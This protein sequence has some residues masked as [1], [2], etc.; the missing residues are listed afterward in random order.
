MIMFTFCA[1]A[2][3]SAWCVMKALVP[4]HKEITDL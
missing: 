4:A 1:L 2:Y 3:L